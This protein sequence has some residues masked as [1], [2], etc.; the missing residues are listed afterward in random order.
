MD[1]DANFRTNANKLDEAV[2]FVNNTI[3]AGY[4]ETNYFYQFNNVTG[5]T[6]SGLVYVPKACKINEVFVYTDVNTSLEVDVLSCVKGV[7][8]FPNQTRSLIDKTI[9][10]APVV[11]NS[12]IKKS[13]KILN[14]WV[15]TLD[16]ATTL[17][18]DVKSN[19]IAKDVNVVIN[20]TK[21][22]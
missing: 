22:T 7:I 17:R 12:E 19:T 18:I 11:L 5:T 13:D 16:D 10:A 20:T 6:A 2:T 4:D 21:L 9:G 15:T 1:K 8:D 14:K 3:P